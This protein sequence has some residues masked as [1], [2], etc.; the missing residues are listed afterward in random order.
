[1][2]EKHAV[3]IEKKIITI[4]LII[5][6]GHLLLIAYSAY[7]L[8]IDVPGCEKEVKP[9]DRGSFTKQGEKRYE[10]HILAKMWSFEPNKISLPLGSVLDLYLTSNDVTHGLHLSYTNTNLTAVPFVVNDAQVKFTPPGTYPMICH[11]Y[12]GSGHHQMSGVIEVRGDITEG[13]AEGL[14]QIEAPPTAGAPVAALPGQK[15]LQEKGCIAC[16]SETGAQGVGP[17]FKGLYGRREEMA[18]GSIVTVDDDYLRESI[19]EPQKRVVKGFNPVMPKLPLSE[20]EVNQMIDYI[21]TLK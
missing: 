7:S 19:L 2:I 12:C 21:K 13:S 8:E 14:P 10:A 6:G 16:H 4:A 18:D 9:F 11:E 20:P 1:M 5:S 3:S 15:L 17:T